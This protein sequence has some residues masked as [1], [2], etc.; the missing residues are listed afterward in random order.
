VV[1]ALLAAFFCSSAFALDIKVIKVTHEMMARHTQ[2]SP[3]QARREVAGFTTLIKVP[4]IPKKLSKL[5]PMSGVAVVYFKSNG[6]MLAW[7][8]KSKTV[9]PGKW[10]LRGK[11]ND[12]CFVFP[13]GMG[14]GVC[15]NFFITTDI[16]KE[17][18]KGNP[19][20][21]QAGAQVPYKLGR[22]GVSLEKIA[23]K[24]D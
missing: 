18:T 2:A 5:I 23:R 4:R 20:K 15:S 7:S 13:K 9:E 21:L 10:F 6:T 3:A 12:I 24:F 14:Q 8:S 22:F 16:V 1:I 17:T 11:R 19:F